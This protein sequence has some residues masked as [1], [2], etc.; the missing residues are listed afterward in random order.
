MNWQPSICEEFFWMGGACMLCV[1]FYAFAMGCIKKNFI[2]RGRSEQTL[3]SEARILVHW[4]TSCSWSE[5]AR[6]LQN[7]SYWV[8]PAFYVLSIVMSV[9]LTMLCMRIPT[10]KSQV[11]VLVVS[12]MSPLQLISSACLSG[13]CSLLTS[14]IEFSTA[15]NSGSSS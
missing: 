12:T 10:M 14:K 13:V 11:S 7:I 4:F 8:Y 2:G 15:F 3:R 6:F 5:V 9:N 1:F